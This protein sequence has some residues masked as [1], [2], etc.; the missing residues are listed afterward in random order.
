MIK[1]KKDTDRI[2]T[3]TLDMEGRAAN[4]INH[5]LSDALVPVI[6]HLQAEKAKGKL[7]GIIITSAKKGFLQGGDLEYLFQ[8]QQASV[9]FELAE[10]FKT[11]LRSLERPGVPVVAAINGD[12]LGAGFELALA[13]H[14]RIAL[15]TSHLRLGFPETRLGV[16]PSGGGIT[17]LMW[18]L[19]V[20]QAYEVL[21]SG[22]LYNAGE[23][24]Q[25]QLIDE[26]A[27]TPRDMMDKA[28]AYILSTDEGCR[29]WDQ[30]QSRIPGGTARELGVAERL[31]ALTASLAAHGPDTYPAEQAILSV[32]YE[33]SKLDFDTS[34][35]VESRHFT[36]LL[37]S[38]VSKNRIKAFWFDQNFIRDGGNRPKGFGKFRPKRVGIIGAGRMGSGIAYACLDHGMEVVL[39][40][41]SKPIAERGLEYV[42]RHLDQDVSRA[43]KQAEEREQLL[44]RIQT[45]ESSA[46]FQDCDIVI[47]AVFENRMVKQK[48][49]RE[50]EEH[51]DEY[52]LF[53]SNTISIPITRLAEASLRPE[54]YLGLHFFSPAEEV[55]LVEIVRGANTS[56][57]TVARAFDFVR[58][59]SK[60]PIVVKDDWGFFAARVQN[61]YILEGITMLQEG[62][63]PA[64]IE[65]LG[66]QTG[67]PRG[68]LALADSLGLNMV[69]R[70]ENQAAEHY[71]TKYVQ[72]PA[73]AVL[74]A[75]LEEWQRPGRQK[76][77]GF[78]TYK[79]EERQQLWA[80]LADAFPAQPA[81]TFDHAELKERFLVAQVLEAVWCMQEK[82]IHSIAAANLGSIH[83]WG[84][85]ASKGGVI[86]YVHDSGVDHFIARC[87]TLQQ[88][89]GQ[90]FRLPSR[91]RSI[92]EQ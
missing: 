81:D 9:V 78:Y 60:T 55:P 21:A 86:Q 4:I 27:A 40:D 71:G 59:I 74:K 14:H 25:K 29:P 37:R 26:I 57:E 61:T 89:H 3:L 10:R 8:A 54:N 16:I 63:P 33:G 41:V 46:D 49:M 5:E 70:Y 75:M 43:V 32:L 69:L 35:R 1:Y 28:K 20:E 30:K 56:D 66:R 67:M 73:V 24:L 50:A 87:K 88:K 39:K 15:D 22:Q 48:V 44:K 64:L 80:G 13:C 11:V 17:R 62:C 53:G 23:A 92:V 45:T 68:A 38:Q 51:M 34:C 12:A 58:A 47:E 83:G 18:L 36:T 42:R 85:P 7:Q 19:G 52:S 79:G 82:V 84:F 31:R 91:L 6:G 65:N 77:A 72:H 2:V 90:R 76:R